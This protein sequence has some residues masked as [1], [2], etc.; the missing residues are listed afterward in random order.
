MKK[1][2][3]TG[4]AVAALGLATQAH[5]VTFPGFGANPSGPEFL[6]TI[7]SGGTASIALNPVY[8]SDPG[9]YDGSDD[10]YIGVVNNSSQTVNSLHLTSNQSIFAFEGDGID[11]GSYLDIPNNAQDNTGY[12]GPNAFFSNIVGNSGDVNFIGG[13]APGDAGIFSLEEQLSTASFTGITTGGVPEPSTW[14]LMLV[15][16]GAV[17]GMLRLRPRT[18]AVPA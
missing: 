13:I 11:T 3:V 14:A 10:T 12:G 5:A 15:G 1:L 18:K 4:A 16:V 17:G 9:P 8:S 2:L 7:D 6:I